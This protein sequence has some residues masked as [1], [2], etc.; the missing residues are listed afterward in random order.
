MEMIHLMLGEIATNSYILNLGNQDAVIIDIGNGAEKVLQA[1]EVYH[2]NLKAILLT[3]GHYDH[4]A[5]VE[6]VRQATGAEVYIHEMDAHMLKS[7]KDNLAWQ[8]T[9][10]EYLPVEK[11][12]T[13]KDSDILEISGHKIE[14]MYTPG[15]TSGG[16]CYLIEDMMFSGD[17]LFKGSVGRTDLGG[18]PNELMHSLKK[19]AAL[20]KN[21]HV[22]PGHFEDSTLD[23]EKASNP[24]LRK[25]S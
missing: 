9:T 22:Y 16:V 19:I 3:H 4:V 25:F 17:T 12:H 15:H 21:Y 10:E 24:Y 2:L 18:N 5:G 13:L 8:L 1:L 14:V 6:Q 20:E 11:Y 23:K 7:E